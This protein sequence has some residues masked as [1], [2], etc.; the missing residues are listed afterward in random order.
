MKPAKGFHMHRKPRSQRADQNQPERHQKR[1]I[2]GSAHLWQR[3]ALVGI[4]LLFCM[5]FIFRVYMKTFLWLPINLHS[6]L[7]ADY[8]ADGL[9]PRLH[10]VQLELIRDAIRDQFFS[11]KPDENSQADRYATLV[12]DLQTPVATVTPLY[13]VTLQ[14]TSFPTQT[15]TSQPLVTATE[16]QIATSTATDIALPDTAT[17]AATQVFNT[18]IPRPTKTTPPQ[19]TNTKRPPTQLPPTQIPPTQPPPTQPPPTATKP[20]TPT[21]VPPTAPPPPTRPPYPNPTGIPY[22]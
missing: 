17:L 2:S 16:T 20:P 14:P 5:G 19:P 10:A 15:A 18:A 11:M 8:S 22:P 13:P 7:K 6:E 9:M 21:K 4:C 3:L 1:T 12:N